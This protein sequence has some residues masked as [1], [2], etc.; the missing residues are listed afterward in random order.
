VVVHPRSPVPPCLAARRA[1]RSSDNACYYV[2]PFSEI[3][4]LPSGASLNLVVGQY[5]GFDAPLPSSAC[6]SGLTYVSQSYTGGAVEVRRVRWPVEWWGACARICPHGG[7]RVPLRAPCASSLIVPAGRVHLHAG[8]PLLGDA[9]PDVRHE[10]AERHPAALL[11]PGAPRPGERTA[12]SWRATNL[13]PRLPAS[14]F[15]AQSPACH[16][17]MTLEVRWPRR[18]VFWELT[19]SSAWWNDRAAVP[20]VALPSCR[21]WTAR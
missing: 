21:R 4:I 11:L 2:S 1:H 18:Q 13:T 17:Y 8:R 19:P 3:E 20:P 9:Q 14:P 16:F 6:A 10:H 5:V 15:A 12:K 7:G